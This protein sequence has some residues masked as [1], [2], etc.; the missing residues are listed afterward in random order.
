MTVRRARGLWITML[1]GGV[2]LAQEGMAPF[3]IP[4][5][6]NPESLVKLP[7]PA[8]IAVDGPRIEARGDKFYV[9]DRRFRV[10]GVSMGGATNPSHEDAASIAERLA[11]GGV[12]SVRFHGLENA[13]LWGRED[14][15]D[16]QK[17]HLD[18][19]DFFLDQLARR[20]I[21]AN[22]NL[23]VSRRYSQELGLPESGEP[24][25]KIVDIFTPVL[26]DAQKK[27]ARGLMNHVNPYRKV[28]YADDPAC[29][30]MEINNEDSLFLWDAAKRLPKLDEYYMKILQ[31]KFNAFLKGRY[32]STEKLRSAWGDGLGDDETIEKGTVKVY[33]EKD[34]EPRTMDR[35]RSLL[36][37]EKAYWDEMYNLLKKELGYKG[38]VTGTIVFGPCNLYAQQNMDWIDCHAYWGHPR[39]AEGERWHAT[40]WT[41]PCAAMA[42]SPHETVTDLDRLT[43]LMFYMASQQFKGKPYTNSEYNHCAPN[44]YQA[45]CVPLMSSFAALQDW[46]GIWFFMYNPVPSRNTIHWFDLDANPSKWGF[47]PAGAAIFRDG[48]VAPFVKTRILSY[49]GT[50]TPIED[51]IQAQLKRNY[52]T[53][54]VLQDR[55]KVAWKDFV[56]TRL[57]TSLDGVKVTPQ[58]TSARPERSHLTWDVAENG[59]GRYIVTGPGAMV[60]IGHAD[61]FSGDTNFKLEKPDFAVVTLTAMDGQELDK[62]KKILVTAIK[63]CENT[64]M[65]F[66]EKRDSV[67]TDW[68]GAPVL[69]EPIA[70]TISGL[71]FLKGDW[72]CQAVGPD[73]NATAQVP[74]TKD[75]KTGTLTL[76]LSPE[77]K[78]MWYLLT[79]K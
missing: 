59:H 69:I 58:A 60:W 14:L 25:D 9:G 78:T 13:N 46:D 23:H 44:D 6:P 20:G 79:S 61:R 11:Q 75:E 32:G 53:F 47:M 33:V 35:M 64:G 27:F 28:R 21:Y 34:A 19:F 63:R 38:L 45:E 50:E 72:Q 12:N 68:G 54:A 22:L 57:V 30:F 43:G 7:P 77:Y 17:E 42:D 5:K 16:A 40:R 62:T 74:L 39:W 4:A 70:G 8:P 67:G 26:I 2:A 24:H 51:M 52:D 65:K 71:P 29:G 10:W 15:S 18:R 73:G 1:M 76:Q 55:Y 37:L 41:V 49:V 31:E 56:D 3:Y 66:N 36:E 48:A